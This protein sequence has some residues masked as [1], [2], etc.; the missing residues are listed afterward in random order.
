[1][2]TYPSL[3][4]GV[5]AVAVVLCLGAA[6]AGR[7]EG[8]VPALKPMESV[9]HARR[10]PLL[11]AARAGSR[12]VAVGAHGVVLLSDDEGKT[13]RQARRVPTDLTLTGVAFANEREG[14][15]VGHAG[16]ILQTSDGG[17]SWALQRSA[18]EDDRPLFAVHFFDRER[19]VAVGLWSL[20]LVTRDGGRQ[21]VQQELAAPPQARRADLNLFGLF[22]NAAGDLYAAAEKGQVLRSTDGG[23]HWTYLPTGYRGSLWAGAALK[24]GTLLVGGLRGAL[25]RSAD[26][27]QSWSRIDSG[28]SASITGLA[29]GEGQAL[30]VTQDGRLLLSDDNGASFRAAPP[31]KSPLRLTAVLASRRGALLLSSQGPAPIEAP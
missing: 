20:V 18:P 23:V 24:D 5:S 8:V 3:R 15:A 9:A 19:G 14:W 28:G 29:A 22:A 26:G 10:A 7:A 1:M 6:A 13:W 30:A 17:E 2:K 4:G 16:V 12:A 21:W 25:Y 31:R 11:A 27:G